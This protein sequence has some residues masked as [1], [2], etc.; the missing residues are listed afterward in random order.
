MAS[1]KFALHRVLIC[2]HMQRQACNPGKLSHSD[3]W[4]LDIN[5]KQG[6]ASVRDELSAGPVGLP[7]MA[8]T[9]M[10]QPSLSPMTGN[11][12]N[13]QPLLPTMSQPALSPMSGNAPTGLPPLPL[14]AMPPIGPAPAVGPAYPIL[15]SQPSQAPG[16]AFSPIAFGAKSYISPFCGPSYLDLP[17]CSS[18]L[19][20][21]GRLNVLLPNRYEDAYH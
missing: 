13:V 2:C 17:P 6:R 5:H 9:I 19:A 18:N 7:P 8:L 3:F 4:Q 21:N 10:P 12:P 14:L 16:A 1:Y 11:A 15:P 20:I